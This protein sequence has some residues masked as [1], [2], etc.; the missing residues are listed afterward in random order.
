MTKPARTGAPN[1]PAGPGTLSRALVLRIAVLVALT[2]ILL[3][4]AAVAMARA[5]W[6]ATVDSELYAAQTRPVDQIPAGLYRGPWASE[7]DMQ[8]VNGEA[9]IAVTFD[10][11]G[12]TKLTQDQIDALMTVKADGRAY[13]INVPGLGQYRVSVRVTPTGEHVAGVSMSTLSS[14]FG[15]LLATEAMFTVA[16]V[17]AAALVAAAVVRVTLRPLTTLAATATRVAGMRLEQGE[18]HLGRLAGEAVKPA[19]EVGQVGM[20]FNH[21][22]D[23]VEDALVARHRSE[24]KVRA[25]V[26]DASHELRNPLAA[27][28]GYSELMAR[29]K[30]LP[31]QTMLAVKRINDESRRMSTLVDEMLLLARL[32]A[33]PMVATHRVDLTKLVVDAVADATVAGPDH[34]WAMDVPDDPVEVVG[35]QNQLHEVV[36]NLLGNARKHTPA[37]T[38]VLVTLRQ[39][40]ASPAPVETQPGRPGRGAAGVTLVAAPPKPSVVLSV[41]DDG[42]GIEENLQP[43][44]FER[45][46]RA[47]QARAHDDEGSTGLGLAI[48]AG[49][50]EAHGGHVALHSAP[51]ATCFTVT[52]PQAPPAP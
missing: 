29:D 6:L 40:S 37:G 14:A 48:V 19:S 44:I 23:N 24:A 30:D 31:E 13:T 43:H 10:R 25:F 1:K 51:G 39:Q 22:L 38:H 2:A 26:A 52:L 15:R 50:V 33:G 3:D 49:V 5:V 27:I 4:S 35:D 16:A 7:I 36:A 9:Q 8:V 34:I 20:A 41:A 28:R 46:V 42:P 18:V 32:D 11:D 17:I 45:F 21:M 47:D 12:A